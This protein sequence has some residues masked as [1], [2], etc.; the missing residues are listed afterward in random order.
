MGHARC[1]CEEVPYHHGEGAD[2]WGFCVGVGG[3]CAKVR[4]FD[5][6][7]GAD[8]GVGEWDCCCEEGLSGL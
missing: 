4:A 7:D 5:R 2:V 1:D 6:V 3:G 8:E